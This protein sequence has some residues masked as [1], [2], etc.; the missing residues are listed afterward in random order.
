M[1]AIASAM[2]L[3]RTSNAKAACMTLLFSTK[4]TRMAATASAMLLF[5][6]AKR[7][8]FG[9]VGLWEIVKVAAQDL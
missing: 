9:A 4:S 3:L 2:L 6:I 8:D 1:A 5:G 7:A